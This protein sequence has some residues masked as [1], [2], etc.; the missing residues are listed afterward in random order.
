MT[1]LIV[2]ALSTACLLTAI[3][4]LLISI[5]KWRG[6]VALSMSTVACLVLRPMGWDQIFYVFASAF[7]GLVSSVVVETVFMGQPE[8][9]SRGLPRRIPPL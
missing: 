4:E 3:E 8:R 1:D 6:L 9:M 7:L 5:G 2:A